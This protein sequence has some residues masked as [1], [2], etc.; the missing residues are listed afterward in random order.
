MYWCFFIVGVIFMFM[1]VNAVH[2]LVYDSLNPKETLYPFLV[3]PPGKSCSDY[4]ESLYPYSRVNKNVQDIVYGRLKCY[5]NTYNSKYSYFYIARDELSDYKEGEDYYVY[6]CCDE[7]NCCEE[8]EEN[9]CESKDT[10]PDTDCCTG[11]KCPSEDEDVVKCMLFSIT[12]GKLTEGLCGQ[13]YPSI[14]TNSGHRRTHDTHVPKDKFPITINTGYGTVTGTRSDISFLFL[15]IPYAEPPVGK[16]RFEYPSPI[17]KLTESWDATHY[18]SYCPQD[19]NSVKN[20]ILNEDCLYLNVYTP[21]IPEDGDS[22]DLRLPVM[23]WIHGG[24]FLRGDVSQPYH[25]PSHL[26]A[27]QNVVAVTFNYRLGILGFWGARNQA[28]RD[29]ITVLQW[30]KE[31]IRDFGGDPDKVTI[32][33]ESAGGHSVRTLLVV[34]QA[35]ELFQGAVSASDPIGLDFA[36][37]YDAENFLTRNLAD[38]FSCISSTT[39]S[40]YDPAVLDCMRKVD[41]S[42]LINYQEIGGIFTSFQTSSITAAE[43]FKPV[44]DNELLKDTF[45]GLVNKGHINNV[46]IVYG[47]L[48]DEG[49]F[50]VPYY[51]DTPAPSGMFSLVLSLMTSFQ[52]AAL[53]KES[54]LYD[55]YK[56][57]AKDG[58]RNAI[59]DV[60][61]PISKM[62]K[63]TKVYGYYYNYSH[64]WLHGKSSFCYG[65]VCHADDIVTLLG[66]SAIPGIENTYDNI[67]T[68]RTSNDLL[69]LNML[70]QHLGSF[71]HTHDP[72]PNINTICYNKDIF[73]KKSPSRQAADW[74]PFSIDNSLDPVPKAPN[75][76]ENGKVY[77]PL[78]IFDLPETQYI[79]YGCNKTICDFWFGQGI[80]AQMYTTSKSQ[81]L[82]F[83]RKMLQYHRSLKF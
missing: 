54:G 81:I 47:S 8:D 52:Q 49:H 30:V 73:D 62:S 44:I 6:E 23:V 13:Q 10:C 41:V 60:I 79:P 40:I 48:R 51:L 74:P 58:T 5:Y 64:Y 16:L 76:V 83:K 75:G 66:S 25:D 31:N 2:L 32:A 4:G 14:C 19:S 9:C 63:H 50:F 71:L 69:F 45:F 33:G 24:S 26:V 35:K 53:I 17:K 56:D 12:D 72:N 70:L 46:P 27:S 15:G 80:H 18:R 78:L 22:S 7:G 37:K 20:P 21:F 38:A 82:G 61:T 67:E 11:E 42:T 36:T 1:S 59:A 65:R 77:G 55:H 34:S 28:I 39:Q 43:T 29:Q 68:P 3:I 57:V